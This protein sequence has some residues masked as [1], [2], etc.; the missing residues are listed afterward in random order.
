MPLSRAL[1]DGTNYHL[2]LAATRPRLSDGMR[3]L[4][5]DYA[6]RFNKRHGR[7]GHLFDERF[8]SFAVE[9]ERHLEAAI[10]YVLQNPVRAGLCD[11]ARDWTWAAAAA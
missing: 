8:S 3:R 11:E 7:R 10:H 9:D 4:N 1:P 5:G 6:R 2:V